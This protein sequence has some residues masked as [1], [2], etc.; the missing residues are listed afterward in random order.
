[1]T[2]VTDPFDLLREEYIALRAEILQSISYQHQILLAGYAASGALFGY[3]T[4]MEKPLLEALLAIPYLLIAMTS[5]WLVECNRMVRA[6]Y[7]I[8]AVLWPDMK[9]QVHYSGKAEWEA[10]IR[11]KEVEDNV[12]WRFSRTQRK[13]QTLVIQI[14]PMLIS[15][16]CI[17]TAVISGLKRQWFL[18]LCLLAGVL[19][20]FLWCIVLRNKCVV[21][22]LSATHFRSK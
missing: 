3:I 21:T 6:G 14:I 19:A 7:Y 5:L 16:L 15:I 10:W 22:D 9:A 11:Q 4:G 20:I 2:D 13:Q 8:G 17:V 12:A 1:M 18:W